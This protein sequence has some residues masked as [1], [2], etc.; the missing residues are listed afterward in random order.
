MV[1][2]INAPASGANTFTNYLNN[3]K[4]ASTSGQGIGDLVGNG[5]SASALP[6]PLPS[7]AELA[8]TPSGAPSGSGSATGSSAS[9]S[10]STSSSAGY[11][12]QSDSLWVLL[13]ALMG[14]TLV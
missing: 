2:A 12:A 13:A 7:G 6:A 9:T 14:I 4:K 10:A 11:I 5:A 8:G 3:A 1:G